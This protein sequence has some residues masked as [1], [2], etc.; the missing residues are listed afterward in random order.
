MNCHC[1]FGTM[2]ASTQ[3]QRGE[4]PRLNIPHIP[5]SLAL[6]QPGMQAIYSPALPTSLQH[7]FHPPLPHSV[8]QTPMQP[9]FNPAQMVPPGAPPRPVHRAGQQSVNMASVAQ[10]AAAGIHP[11]NGFPITPMGGHFPRQSIAGFPVQMPPLHHPFPNRNRRQLSIGGPPKAVLGGPQRRLSPNPL[12][13]SNDASTAVSGT[14]TPSGPPAPN[15]APPL[16]TKKIVVNLPKET[17]PS[18]V[19]GVAANK[20]PFARAPLKPEETVKDMGLTYPETMTCPEFPT[21]MYRRHI[22]P[23]VDVFL[24]GKAS[25]QALKQADIEQKLEKL[26][27][28]R[29]GNSSANSFVQVH[30][31]HGRAASISSPADPALLMFKLNKLH[32]SQQISSAGNSL[33]TSP[34]PPFLNAPFSATGFSPSPTN[35]ATIPRF[36][37]NRHGHSLS[38]AQPPSVDLVTDIFRTPSTGLTSNPFGPNAILG[39]DHNLQNSVSPSLPDIDTGVD[40]SIHAPQGR[41][42]VLMSTLESNGIPNLAPPLSAVRTDSRPDFARGFGLEIPEEADEENLEEEESIPSWGQRRDVDQEE[43]THSERDGDGGAEDMSLDEEER[44]EM[45]SNGLLTAPQSRHHSRHGSRLSAALSLRSFGGLVADGLNERMG[46]LQSDNASLGLASDS[47]VGE[48]TARRNHPSLHLPRDRELEEW[49]GSEDVDGYGNVDDDMAS[50]DDSIGE[51]SNPS[52]EERARQARVDARFQRRNLAVPSEQ[53]RKL[54]SFPR[55]PDNTI[56]VPRLMH[57]HDDDIISNPSEEERGGYLSLDLRYPSSAVMGSRPL[58]PVPGHH[59]RGPSPQSEIHSVHDPARAHSRVPSPVQTSRETPQPK[60]NLNPNAKPFVFGANGTGFAFSGVAANAS[61]MAHSRLP[62]SGFGTRL[63]AAAAEFRPGGSGS[64]S[65]KASF[66]VPSVD[67][68]SAMSFPTPELSF[69]IPQV[70][71][72]SRPLPLPPSR[73][74]IEFVL[75]MDEGSPFK[76]QGREKRQRRDTSSTRSDADFV[77]GDSIASFRFPSAFNSPVSLRIGVPSS[78]RQDRHGRG[79]SSLT[80]GSKL[81]A[82]LNPTAE[83][84]TFAGFT[85]AVGTLPQIGGFTELETQSATDEQEVTDGDEDK[86]NNANLGIDDMFTMPS[87]TKARRAPIPLDFKHTISNNTVP[88]GLFKALANHSS[89]NSTDE[90]TRPTVRSRLSSREQRPREFGRE[91]ERERDREFYELGHSQRPSLDDLGVDMPAISHKISR[92]RLVTDPGR[93]APSAPS[94]LDDIFASVSMR[95]HARRRSS[96]PEN[97]EGMRYD[98]GS[99][100]SLDSLSI[101]SPLAG[102]V[103]KDLP[104]R[105]EMRRYEDKLESLLDQK[106]SGLSR[107]LQTSISNTSFQQ[108]LTPKAEEMISDVVSLFRTQLADSAVRGLDELHLDAR[109]ELDFEL[110]KDVVEQ[111]HDRILNLM[112]QELKNFQTQAQ[113]RGVSGPDG[114][115]DLS[116]ALEH[117]SGRTINAVVEVVSELSVRLEAIARGAPSRDHDQLVDA[118]VSALNPAFNAIHPETVDYDFL[119]EKLSQAVKP[120]ISQIIDLASDKR[121]TAGL[122]V[123]SLLPVLLPILQEYSASQIDTDSV[124]HQLTAEVRRAIAPIDAF[125]IKEQVADLVVERLDSRLAVR[126]KAFNVESLSGKIIEHVTQLLNPLDNWTANLVDILEGQKSLA[127]QQSNLSAAHQNMEDLVTT[128][129]DKVESLLK[130]QSL[131][132]EAN[133]SIAPDH[134]L[135]VKN[136]LGD[137]ASVQQ[138]L[139]GHSTELLKLSK[140]LLSRMSALPDSISNA[141]SVLQTSHSDLLLTRDQDKRELDDLRRSNTDLQVQVHKARGAHGQVR[142]EKD[143]FHEKLNILEADRERLRQQIKE[144][145]AMADNKISE[146]ASV[147]GKNAD[148]EEALAKALGRLQASDVATQA[149]MDLI[150][151]L[152]KA[153]AELTDEKQNLKTKADSLELKVTLADGEKENAQQVYS[154]LQKQFDQLSSQQSHWDDLRRTAE[155]VEQLTNLIGQADTVELNELRGI[156]EYN[157]VLEGEHAALQKR[158]KEQENR[159]AANEKANAPLKQSLAN[160]TA[161]ASEWERRAKESEAKLERTTT[162]LEQA[163]QTHSQLDADYLVVKMQLEDREA[164]DRLA[165]DRENRLRE[166]IS[167]LEN[168]TRLLQTELEKARTTVRN[169]PQKVANGRTYHPISRPDSRAS[170][171]FV[172]RSLTPNGRNPRSISPPNHTTSVWDSIHA[173]RAATPTKNGLYGSNLYQ[174]TP[175]HTPTGRYPASLSRASTQ[176]HLQYTRSSMASPT[177]STVSL[178][179]TR[180]SARFLSATTM[181]EVESF[182]RKIKLRLVESGEWDRMKAAIGPKLNDSG[183]KDEMKD[184]G[185]GSFRSIRNWNELIAYV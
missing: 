163:E 127:G 58:P 110:I 98:M 165:Q 76:I 43:D 116:Q 104:A 149:N 144:L 30:A 56:A 86:E 157:R 113:L 140:D 146:F 156:R 130:A 105:L 31:P 13:S 33:S 173:P 177:P 117:Y 66:P 159:A 82:S 170:T 49:T 171:V 143:M 18:E 10:L 37:T 1:Q 102:P 69:P 152:E 35:S 129:P 6:Q 42:P 25:W 164:S 168:K 103:A 162:Q 3:R 40:T 44:N 64:F 41:K 142:V 51:W 4:L 55:P 45:E 169:P 83:P 136:V 100:D 26:G 179:P 115:S 29:G 180:L 174:S 178:A 71:T 92:S 21:E 93:V 39:H 89:S 123:D 182:Y 97:I 99:P 166:E 181:A 114:A 23:T 81:S 176:S 172:D 34:Q 79:P 112:T 151:A 126:D 91:L 32:Q 108:G 88:A 52:D 107:D 128:L 9:F 161:R 119:T 134:I 95:Q 101:T 155:Q 27:V 118:V 106:L 154:L 85:N 121:E 122:I 70:Q 48:P 153:N 7:S 78:P 17:I 57:T 175:E 148:L 63:N 120:H 147:E 183:W 141:A 46:E 15:S 19:E 28:E 24:P 59:S 111:G 12:A 167:A 47:G 132:T 14:A 184:K 185:V 74:D 145:Q 96:L 38:L 67:A 65:F 158:F 131:A 16:K 135:D 84:F 36:I 11:P 87:S 139:A 77:E 60:P 50:D 90:R 80:S 5:P 109:G 150:A 20:A 94:P 73:R 2:A 62:S 125:E 137:I 160:A 22:P 53:P 61:D 138:S 54:P 68:P 8:M 133:Q 75:N 124:A 72:E